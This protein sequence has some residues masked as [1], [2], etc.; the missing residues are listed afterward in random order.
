MLF[1]SIRAK[2]GFNNNPTVA[3][4]EAAYKSI[5]VHAEIKSPSSANCMALDDT[6]IL[7]VSSTQSKT[8]HLQSELLDLLCSAGTDI[9][10]DDEI[11]TLYQHD[12]L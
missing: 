5:I 2:G 11:I 6:S 9:E 12:L 4:F 1:S 10:E 8:E 3:Q 7:R